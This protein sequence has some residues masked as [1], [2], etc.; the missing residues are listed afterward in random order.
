MA[1]TTIHGERQKINKVIRKTAWAMLVVGIM[2]T[3]S[4]FA[5]QAEYKGVHWNSYSD[6]VN[7]Y[8]HRCLG[9]IT[10]PET[11]EQYWSGF[12]VCV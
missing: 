1:T 7:Y 2:V 4:G 10:V 8:I 6:N 3:A 9:R 12:V 11:Y 5:I